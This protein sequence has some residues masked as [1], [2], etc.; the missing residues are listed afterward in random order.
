MA[1]MLRNQRHRRMFVGRLP[2]LSYA[3]LYLQALLLPEPMHPVAADCDTFAGQEVVRFSRSAP[4]LAFAEGA[5]LLSQS[6]IGIEARL[7]LEGRTVPFQQP[8]G[9]PLGDGARRSR[10]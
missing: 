10:T 3:L 5:Q 9:Y 7:V 8:A 6:R 2:F 4:P 1:R